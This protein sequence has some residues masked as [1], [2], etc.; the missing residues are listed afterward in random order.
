MLCLTR[1]V[2]QVLVLRRKDSAELRINGVKIPGISDVR[3]RVNK[4][5]G[6]SVQLGIEA[7]PHIEILREELIE[8][9]ET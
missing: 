9:E 8:R 4:I 7:P 3:I 5:D 2:D 6:R 1:K